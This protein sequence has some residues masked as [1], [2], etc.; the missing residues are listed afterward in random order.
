M[1]DQQ[2]I[3]LWDAIGRVV[4]ASGGDPGNTSVARQRAVVEVEGIIY[5]IAKERD[6]LI[7]ER[8]ELGRLLEE[9]GCDCDC[10]HHQDE[11]EPDCGRCLACRVEEV[12]KR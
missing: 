2:R 3:D 5:S 12:V 4:Q 6:A 10:G 7:K 1:T 8:D 11:H 9:N